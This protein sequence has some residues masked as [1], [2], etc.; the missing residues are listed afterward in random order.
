MLGTQTGVNSPAGEPRKHGGHDSS[1]P[2][3]G[4]VGINEGATHQRSSDAGDQTMTYS[5]QGPAS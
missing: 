3:G 4:L 5:R 2:V 1:L